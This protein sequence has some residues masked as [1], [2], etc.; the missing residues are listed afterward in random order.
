MGPGSHTIQVI[1]GCDVDSNG[2]LLR[3]Y[4]QFAYDG[5]NYIFLNEDL[6][7]W[8]AADTEAAQITRQKLE[9]ADEAQKYKA[10]LEGECVQMLLRY[11]EM[12]NSS[13]CTGARDQGH[14]LT[15][16]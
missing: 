16:P 4:E 3:G 12:G 14:L 8:T 9:Q 15:L 5:D 1:S 10:Y 11:L 13:L 6:R 7:T 2:L